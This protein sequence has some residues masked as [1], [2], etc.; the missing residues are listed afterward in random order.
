MSFFLIHDAAHPVVLK[1]ILDS[2]LF[3]MGLNGHY[4]GD[5]YPLCSDLPQRHFLRKGAEYRLLGTVPTPRLLGQHSAWITDHSIQRLRLSS[6]SPLFAALCN[7]DSTSTCNYKG[8]VELKETLICNGSECEVDSPR[9]IEVEAGLYYEYTRP[10]C[11]EQSFF[12]NGVLLKTRWSRYFCSDPRLESGTVG[13][14]SNGSNRADVSSVKFNGELVKFSTATQRCDDKNLGLCD[15]PWMTCDTC[16][17]N[18]GYW[19]NRSCTPMAKINIDGKVAIV[20]NAAGNIDANRIVHP[21]RD[22]TKT[23]FCVEWSAG[24]DAFLQSYEKSCANLGCARD[25]SDNLCVCPTDV[26]EQIVFRARPTREQ[27]LEQLKVGAFSPEYNQLSV[28]NLGGGVTMYSR[29]TQYSDSTIFEVEDDNGKRQYRK[30]VRST[31]SVGNGSM[32]LSFRNPPHFI[33]VGYPEIRDA[34]YETDAGLD[35]YLVS[36]IH[37][38]FGAGFVSRV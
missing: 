7:R 25:S 28:T 30:N 17:P 4:V 33:S 20:H 12:E 8:V 29:G 1:L 35:H 10:P 34:A 19:T 5:H 2:Y 38:T 21:V 37:A 32:P 27:V 16:D 23:Y 36:F 22:D 14:C 6:S 18:L 24:F 3:Q 13:C 11:V 9:I 26:S 15:N 31:V